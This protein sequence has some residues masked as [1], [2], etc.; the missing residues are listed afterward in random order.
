MLLHYTQI[1]SVPAQFYVGKIAREGSVIKL[2]LTHMIDRIIN[3]QDE[4]LKLIRKNN[5]GPVIFPEDLD[6]FQA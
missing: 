1:L 5:A 4:T 3:R 6:S 2:L